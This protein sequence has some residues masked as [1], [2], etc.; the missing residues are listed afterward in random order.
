MLGVLLYSSVFFSSPTDGVLAYISF[1]SINCFFLFSSYLIYCP[2]LTLVSLL[3]WK[4]S[5]G[6]RLIGRRRNIGGLFSPFDFGFPPFHCAC[7][8]QYDGMTWHD[9][10]SVLTSRRHAPHPVAIVMVPRYGCTPCGG[11]L[12]ATGSSAAGGTSVA[13]GKVSASR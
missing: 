10:H 6:Y 7:R 11:N 12:S 3:L 9:L 4:K 1:R 13:G 8:A 5:V 2:P